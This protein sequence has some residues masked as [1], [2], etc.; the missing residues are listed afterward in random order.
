MKLKLDENLGNRGATLFRA[1]GHDVATVVEQN[2]T[3]T[4]D[5]DLLTICHSEERALVSCWASITNA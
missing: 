5:S 1:T 3:S 2:L 4:P